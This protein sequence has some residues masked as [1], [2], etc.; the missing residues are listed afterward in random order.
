MEV[1][2]QGVGPSTRSDAAGITTSNRK[3]RSRTSTTA[4]AY[5]SDIREWSTQND[6][7]MQVF[8]IGTMAVS[9]FFSPP[10][11]WTHTNTHAHAR[12]LRA[13]RRAARTHTHTSISWRTAANSIDALIEVPAT[14]P[15]AAHKFAVSTS[16]HEIYGDTLHH[17]AL[18]AADLQGF[19]SPSRVV[20]ARP[21]QQGQDR[22]EA[23]R[24][25]PTCHAKFVATPLID[26]F[27]DSGEGLAFAGSF[28]CHLVLVFYST[29]KQLHPTTLLQNH[30]PAPSLGLSNNNQRPPLFLLLSDKQAS[31]QSNN[32]FLFLSCRAQQLAHHHKIHGK[33]PTLADYRAA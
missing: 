13:C 27:S 14:S 31:K 3:G 24:N 4:H 2:K 5:S 29:L 33:P 7:S 12:T 16:W 30:R 11:I 22:G 20:V 10:N 1:A 15:F 26:L 25:S 32:L 28:T 18:F 19:F 23:S 9:P 17:T 21:P 6:W 8:A